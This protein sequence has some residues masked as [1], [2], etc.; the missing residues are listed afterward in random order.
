MMLLAGVMLGTGT[1]AA[2]ADETPPPPAPSATPTPTPTPTPS[3]SESRPGSSLVITSPAAGFSPSKSVTV[4]GTMAAGSG[5]AVTASGSSGCV[6]AATDP[7][8]VEWSCTATLPNGPGLVITATETLADGTAGGQDTVTVGVLGAPTIDKVPPQKSPGVASGTGYRGSSITLF[9]N[10]VSQACNAPVTDS[11]KW[12][13]TI[14]GGSGNYS[15]RATQT[16]PSMGTSNPSAARQLMVN[17][18][19]TKPPAPV[20]PPTSPE[21]SPVLP[22]APAVPDETP[23]RTPTPSPTPSERAD[24]G[25]LPWLERPIFPGHSGAGPTIGEALT[26]WGTPTGFGAQLPTPGETAA[27]GSWLWAP[28]FALAFI[29]LIAMPLRLLASALRGRFSFRK[30]QLAGRNRRNTASGEPVPRNP[31]LMG[32]V[33]LAATAGLVVLAEGLNGEVRYVRLLFAVGAGLAILNVVGVAITSKL[34]SDRLGVIGRLRFVPILLIIAAIATMIARLTGMEPPLVGGALIGVGF[35]LTVPVRPR[36]LVN[37][38]G[39]G[40]VLLLAVLAWVAH[41]LVGPVDGFWAS[42]F[43]E[44]LATVCLAGVGSALI[45]MLPIGALPGRVV[46]EW[47]RRAWFTTTLAVGTL[48]AAVLLPGVQPGITMLTALLVVTG[49]AAICVAVWA[50]SNYIEVARA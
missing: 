26:N 35:A 45:L 14:A 31:W 38:A 47:S 40:G 41:G 28:L 25:T 34:A 43:S 44:L 6:A 32:A 37:L 18:T 11:G 27:G 15:V 50:W 7:S 33:P 12:L 23:E 49:F 19:P 29:S 20:T 3:P 21:P 46:L 1:A 22:P 42:V 2:S 30:P 48:A 4:G 5:V 8:S 13:C 16:V 9:V 17:P 24:A 36:A 10:G 39:V